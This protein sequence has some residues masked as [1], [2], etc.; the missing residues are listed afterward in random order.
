MFLPPF[1]EG[2]LSRA[3]AFDGEIYTPKPSFS[4]ITV[5]IMLIRRGKPARFVRMK[6]RASGIFG[7]T[8]LVLTKMRI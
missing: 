7:S 2:G 1:P 3:M 8:G 5:L 4:L 6:P